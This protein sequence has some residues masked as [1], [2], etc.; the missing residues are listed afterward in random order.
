MLTPTKAAPLGPIELSQE[1]P[2]PEITNRPLPLP[3]K[4]YLRLAM[5][6]RLVRQALIERT[7][8]RTPKPARQ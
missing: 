1:S 3:L 8:E 2:M 7:N 5:E 4:H 6:Q